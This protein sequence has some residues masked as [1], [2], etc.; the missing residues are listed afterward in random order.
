MYDV[1][2]VATPPPVV[3]LTTPLTAPTGTV[4]TTEVADF[5]L[6]RALTPPIV[7]VVTPPRLVPDT[8]IS[9]PTLPVTGVKLVIVGATGVAPT[10]KLMALTAV[11]PAVITEIV[12]VVAPVG[13]AVTRDVL[14]S[15]TK[16]VTAT[17]LNLTDV[18]PTKLVPVSVTVAPTPPVVGVKE[19]TLGTAAVALTVKLVALVTTPP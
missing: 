6:K 11:P 16:D 5:T 3:T 14:E 4:M 15:T 1:A 17:P 18:D 8:V 13:T 12:P 10:V 2:E 9:V 19:V 7:A